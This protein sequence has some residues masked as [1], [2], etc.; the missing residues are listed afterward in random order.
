MAACI[1]IQNAIQI[2]IACNRWPETD[3]LPGFAALVLPNLPLSELTAAQLHADW[4]FTRLGSDPCDC[5]MGDCGVASLLEGCI[6]PSLA[7][8]G[9]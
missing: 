3:I 4:M 8:E 6:W 1:C 2:S 5:Y 9:S 7:C